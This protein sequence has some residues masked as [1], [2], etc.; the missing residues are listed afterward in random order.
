MLA[1][2]LGKTR[3]ITNKITHLIRGCGYPAR[4][5]A[6]VTFTSKAARE[7]KEGVSARRWGVKE[8]RGTDDLHVP[9]RWGWISSETA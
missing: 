4:H 5:I 6:A 8:A 3:V 7:M 2:W 1:S 9:T